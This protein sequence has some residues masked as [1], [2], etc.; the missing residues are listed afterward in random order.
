MKKNEQLTN[1]W[2]LY[3]RGIDYKNRIGL[4]QTSQDNNKFF[5]GDQWQGVESEG[6]PTPVFNIIKPVIRYKVST[7]MQNDVKIVYTCGNATS[8]N[9]PQLEQFADVLTKYA[10][11]MWERLKMDFLNDNV[12]KDA[13]IQ[14]DGVCHFFW[15]DGIKAELID[16]TNLYVANQNYPNIEEQEYIIISYRQNVSK[17]KRE[18]EK[19]K[20]KD[21]DLITADTD[22]NEQAGEWVELQDEGMCIV[23]LKYWKENGTVHFRKSTKSVV[24]VENEDTMLKRYPIAFFNWESVKNSF[25]GVSDVT[26]LIPN[27]KYINTIAALIQ[28]STMHTA[29]PK[30]VY[31]SSLI[32]NPDN[33]V[34]V[35]IG[36]N[37]A[38][39]VK[40]MI[41][42]IMPPQISVD[43]FKMFDTTITLT[44]DLMGA[45]ESALGNINP[46]KASGRS[47]LAI[48]E[49][50][51]IPLESI[52][53]RFFNYIEDIALIWSDMWRI[54]SQEG[55]Q[56]TFE[57]DNNDLQ[58]AIIPQEVFDE[59]M[60]ETKIDIGPS[61]RWTERAL[62]ETL[63]NLLTNKYMPFEW[64]V[65]LMPE[66]SGLPKARLKEMIEQAKI[67]QMQ[68]PQMD[69]DALLDSLPPEVQQ[70]ALQDPSI[71]ENIIAE[72]I[73]VQ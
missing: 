63:D 11:T 49:Q 62:M 44:K 34:G 15:E 26:G 61:T 30:M 24:M 29:F 8:P 20:V 2:V 13:A 53:R 42:Y 43:A 66:G 3:Q 45:N 18:A 70:Q 68:Q 50:S 9:Y 33:A 31:N 64:Y 17:V 10:S 39:N 69:I 41:D 27:Q 6:L 21:L 7:I 38:E 35:A 12:L 46:E 40:N 52:R 37:G 58:T 14:G 47:I 55:L 72:R 73:G 23:L 5:Q 16:N 54:H 36:V 65:E 59:L 25:H 4:Y 28:F 32:D 57:N 56:V 60:L 67:Q 48:I 51:A 19:Y 71:L 22:I 1:E